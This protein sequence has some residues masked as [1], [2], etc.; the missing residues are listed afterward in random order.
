MASLSA[1]CVYAWDDLRPRGG[2]SGTILDDVPTTD[3][4]SDDAP[5]A[6]VEPD[7]PAPQDTG[8][9]AGVDVGVDTGA[10][11][12]GVDAGV[13]SGPRDTGVDVGFDT[14]PRDTGIDVGFDTGPRDTGIDVGFD[15]GPRD[16][17]IDVGFDT[18]PRDTG[19]DVGFD[20]GPADTGPPPCTG[21]SCPCSPTLPTGWCALGQACTSGACVPITVTGTLVITEVMNDTSNPIPEPEGEWIEVYNPAPYGVDIRGLR[22]RDASLV[23]P[24]STSTTP[25]IV[26]PRGYAVLGRTENLGISGGPRRTLATYD[27]VALNNSGTETVTL[28]TATGTVIDTISYG[29]GWPNTSGR[30][31]SL[32]PMLLDAEMNNLSTNWCAGGPSFHTDNFGT[33]GAANVCE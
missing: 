13:D 6:A 20:T 32:R 3:A 5:D 19:I 23:S 22:V 17:G 11:D 18:G 27:M 31:K 1:G 9:D 29:T 16:T 24:I 25:L 21:P 30:S 10:R 15:T 12:T 26:P 8:V 2:D 33:P 28:E 14:G 7:V 4:P